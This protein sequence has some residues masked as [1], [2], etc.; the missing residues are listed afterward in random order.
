MTLRQRLEMLLSIFLVIVAI[1][2]LYYGAELSLEASEKVGRR[3]GLSPLTIGMLLIGFGT[4]LPEFFVG[5]IASMK[6]KTDIAVGSLVGSNIA[7]MFLIL[8]VSALIA[9]LPL[10]SKS[11]KE[12]LWVHLL[13]SVT[14][15]IVLSMQ[16]INILSSLLLLSVAMVYVYFIYKDLDRTYERKQGEVTRIGNPV[17]LIVK[18]IAGFGLLYT[19]GELLVKGGTD[20]TVELGV[21]EYIVSAIF[22]AF[23]TSFPEL[24]TSLIACVKKKNTDLIVG[25]I[26]GSNLFNCSLILGSLGVYDF[27]LPG[28]L[29]VE[30]GMLIFGSLVL[31]FVAHF[32][33]HFYR[34]SGVIF[35]TSYALM[36]FHW[37]KVF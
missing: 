13:L 27:A 16:K 31:V 17:M 26:V 37:M 33:K 6:G 23:G 7:N 4:S 29:K 19:G 20:I 12:H 2:A 22:I 18:M 24:V 32:R 14:L 9:K 10:L 15:A 3:I 34:L 35:I 36:V 1:V 21:S 5:H 25:N 30:W 28:Q 11:I 8:G